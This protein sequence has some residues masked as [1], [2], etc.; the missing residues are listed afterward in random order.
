MR[1]AVDILY[2]AP[3]GGLGHATRAAAILRRALR[4][5]NP[6]LLAFVTT[7]HAL[8]LDHEGIPY[9]RP[10]DLSPEGLRAE[11]EALIRECRLR[12]LA[13]DTFPFGITGELAELLP[14]LDCRKV[15]VA[16]RLQAQWAAW[17]PPAWGG[18]DRV[19]LA[20]AWEEAAHA[21]L[22]S[23]ILLRDA[24]ELWPRERAKAALGV[25]A[26]EPVVLGVSSDAADWTQVF[27]NLLRK[28]WARL[29][30]QAR[31]R[32]AS[33]HLPAGDPLRVAHYPLLELMHGV[34]LVVGPCGYNLFHEAQ[35]CGVPAVFLPQ[36]RRYDNQHARA[37]CS[38]T[39]GTP[40]GLEM[41]LRVMMPARARAE[42]AEYVNGA[43]T[44]AGELTWEGERPREPRS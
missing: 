5:G 35:A 30:P 42:A 7:P 36:P 28:I 13:V 9:H 17:G 25:G 4:L 12:V 24:D 38:V 16:R 41:R 3:G 27:F 29:R 15:L 23:P 43:W 10:A 11:A 8:P 18:F 26:D 33:P 19:L 31:L 21:R 44:A 1:S 37:I 40:E 39:A 2:Y 6:S 34:D 14:A 20:E 22:C 32:L